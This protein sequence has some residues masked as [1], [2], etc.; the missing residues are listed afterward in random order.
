MKKYLTFS[1]LYL[2]PFVTLA[3]ETK[4]IKGLFVKV[5]GIINQ[6]TSVVFSLAILFFIW[7]IVVY[8]TASGQ[9]DKRTEAARYMLWG[10]IVIFVMVGVYGFINL[11]LDTTGFEAGF[12]LPPFKS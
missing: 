3:Q 2:I 12:F 8:L 7:N 9:S 10:I 11:L 1:T 4:G 5:L 6:L